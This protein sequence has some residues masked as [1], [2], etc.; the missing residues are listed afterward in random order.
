MSVLDELSSAI[1][2]RQRHRRLGGRRYRPRIRG[3]GVVIADGRVL[4]NA[5]N[6][7]G[8]EVTVTFRDGRS[9]RRHR[10]RRRPDGDLAVVDVD[11]SGATALDWSD[12]DPPSATSS[13]GWRRRAAAPARVTAGTISAVER[14]F[15]GPGGT[16]IGGQPRAHGAPGPGLIRWP[17]G[18]RLG[19][20][21]ALNTNRV[22]RGLLPRPPGRRRAARAGRRARPRRV[23]R[24]GPGSGSPSR[25][26]R[27]P[28]ASERRS[29]WPTATASS[30]A[31]S[32]TT[33]PPREP[34]SARATS[35]SRRPGEP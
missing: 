11:T 9:T 23:G 18:R 21:L 33:A 30:S 20:L 17:A 15:R 10:A 25:R 29:V 7:R 5:H 34:G 1:R 8:E 6:L 31:A 2:S 27:S 35:S 22:G 19:R 26:R 32:R 13:S 28:A 14:T 3:S 4:T 12:A 16:R 24:A